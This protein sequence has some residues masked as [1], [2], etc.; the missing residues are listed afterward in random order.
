MNG[1]KKICFVIPYFGTLPNYFPVFLK[2]CEINGNFDWLL[3]TDDHRT[4]DYPENVKV[5]YT[6]FEEMRNRIEQRF[7]F[8]ISLP[9]PKKL[10]DFKPT[11]G[12]IFEEELKPYPYWGYCDI[13]LV[14]GDLDAFLDWSELKKYRK[15]YYLGHMSIYENTEE[16]RTLFLKGHPHRESPEA[17]FGYMDV[18]GN[19]R[20][21]V[22]DE[23]A[24]D[25]ETI[26]SVAEQEGIEINPSFPMLDIRPWRS[27][28]YST[29]FDRTVH[30][31]IHNWDDNFIVTWEKGK[32]F[33]HSR[34]ADGSLQK[35]EILY[36]HF[37]KRKMSMIGLDLRS[38]Y[39]L[40]WPNRM[41]SCEQITDKMIKRK[42]LSA[43]CRRFFRVEEN[44]KR[45]ND[46]RALW[47]HR[48]NKYIKR[49]P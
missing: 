16:M 43:K 8:H 18:L 6:T 4:F 33:A 37:Q 42:M 49:K 1:E 21:F 2:S 23:W 24:D 45:F 35:K 32:L 17:S 31:W 19:A 7:P 20:N 5:C 48:Y 9:T 3:F 11:Y 34:N 36:A 26:N 10:C 41:Q 39:I 12:F 15:H 29:V 46:A 28:F 40:F 44:A 27:R 14:L 30:T 47:K 13:D 22:Y 25:V 38:E